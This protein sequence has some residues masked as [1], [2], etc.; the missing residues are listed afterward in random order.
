MSRLKASQR[1]GVRIPDLASFFFY[2]L[3]G[4]NAAFI[5]GGTPPLRVILWVNVFSSSSYLIANNKCRVVTRFFLL[6]RAALP[7]SSSISAVR[8]SK[9]AAVPDT[10]STPL[11]WR[12][13][14]SIRPTGNTKPAFLLLL[15]R[16][17]LTSPVAQRLARSAVNRKAV[18]SNPIW[19]VF[20]Y[21][22]IQNET[23]KWTYKYYG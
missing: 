18:G 1:P 14:V 7:D 20:F 10:R 4:N 8:Y 9:T 6:S 21:W 2:F 22:K 15:P 12:I 11:W 3:F 23:H 13:R 16:P 5:Y 17:W 19:G